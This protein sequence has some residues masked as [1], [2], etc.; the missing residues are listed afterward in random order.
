MIAAALQ[1]SKVSHFFQLVCLHPQPQQEGKAHNR[2]RRTK[3]NHKAR[4]DLQAGKIV[5]PGVNEG[6]AQHDEQCQAHD[7]H[8]G[9]G[10]QVRPGAAPELHDGVLPFVGSSC[11]VLH[12]LRLD[13]LRHGVRWRRDG[14][15]RRCRRRSGALTSNTDPG[16]SGRHPSSAGALRGRLGRGRT[17]TGRRVTCRE[18]RR[19][20][21]HG[22]GRFGRRLDR[23]DC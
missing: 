11:V 7:E 14:R 6:G 21:L 16:C 1:V 2:G 18:P 19:L 4:V 17:R 12:S 3:T 20:E 22:K 8:D 10:R 9:T 15:R 23:R 5:R 13:G